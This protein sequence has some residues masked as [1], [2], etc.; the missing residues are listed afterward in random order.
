MSSDVDICNV[1][2]AHVGDEA[3]VEAIDPP[4][5]SVQAG[6]CARFYPIAR[7]AMIEAGPWTFA[8]ARAELAEVA[9]NDSDVW[10]YAYALPS[11][12][13]KPLRILRAYDFPFVMAS[14]YDIDRFMLNIGG[15]EQDG[16]SFQIQGRTLYTHEPEAMLIY[17]QDVVDPSKFTP[18]FVMG[19]GYMLA[20]LLAGP[21]VKGIEGV[22]LS[23]ALLELAM[24]VTA[25]AATLDANSSRERNDVMPSSIRA[26]Q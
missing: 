2:L 5:G 24:Q 22:R 14:I 20:S 23:R 12:C 25:T 19:L 13:V 7:R 10:T 3:L 4:D 16:A 15:D 17:R 18:N 21:I 9:T 11:L 26:R 1:A 6:H 8:L